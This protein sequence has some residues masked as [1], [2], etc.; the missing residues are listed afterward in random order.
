M[1]EDILN[2]LANGPRKTGLVIPESITRTSLLEEPLS[3]AE[4][5]R[6]AAEP[7]ENLTAVGPQVFGGAVTVGLGAIATLAGTDYDPPSSRFGIDVRDQGGLLT[8]F[9]DGAGRYTRTVTTTP[10]LGATCSFRG[11]ES[12]GS[13]AF[14]IVYIGLPAAQV[15]IELVLGGSRTVL[16]DAPVT[17]PL[18]MALPF[19]QEQVAQWFADNK[20]GASLEGTFVPIKSKVAP[21]KQKLAITH[22]RLAPHFADGRDFKALANP[23]T[24]GGALSKMIFDS[25]LTVV[26]QQLTYTGISTQG[27]LRYFGADQVGNY[28]FSFDVAIQVPTTVALGVRAYRFVVDG[29]TTTTSAP[30]VAAS[31]SGAQATTAGINYTLKTPAWFEKDAAIDAEVRVLASNLKGLMVPMRLPNQPDHRVSTN[32]SP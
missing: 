21:T 20:A 32:Y 13:T 1:S 30:R 2:P 10:A 12:R 25:K 17:G 16:L 3:A 4:L 24:K 7:E 6:L 29:V 28:A 8:W 23:G 14:L 9:P 27:P 31:S 26:G 15:K 22:K 19:S 11:V 5:E 18:Y